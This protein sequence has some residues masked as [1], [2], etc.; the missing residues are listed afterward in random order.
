MKTKARIGITAAG[1]VFLLAG[2]LFAFTRLSGPFPL[3]LW[4]VYRLM[5]WQA[6]SEMQWNGKGTLLVHMQPDDLVPR[7]ENVRLLPPFKSA[8]L[9]GPRALLVYLP[10]AYDKNR[11]KPYPVIYAFHG[12]GDRPNSFVVA[13]LPYIEKAILAKTMP[14]SVVVMPDF[15]LT[16][17]GKTPA[18]YPTDGRAGSWYINSN[19]GRFED[20]FFREIV[21]FAQTS[22]R[23][24]TSPGATA[25]IG[26]SMGGFGALYY[27]ITHPAF[28]HHVAAVYPAADLRYGV[29]GSRLADYDPALYAPIERDDPARVMMDGELAGTLGVGEEFFYYPVFDSDRVPGPVWKDDR[30]VWERLRDVNPADILASRRI[31]LRGIE[32]YIFAG[33]RDQFNFDAHLPLVLPLLEKAG[34]RVKPERTIIPGMR[35]GWWQKE[36]NEHKQALLRWLAERLNGKPQ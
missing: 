19:L 9:E 4:L 24:S 10:P 26:S 3:P 8:L 11:A 6:Y 14:A 29:G 35:H 12:F 21:P 16:G 30:P 32:Y 20:H 27:S 15:S 25:I 2:M 22:F 1:V 23:I 34:A 17:N 31:D 28:A 7:G 5:V 36:D 13:L 33:D 18:G